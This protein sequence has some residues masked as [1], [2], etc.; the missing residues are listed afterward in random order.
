MAIEKH[1]YD[2]NGNAIYAETANINYFLTTPLEP[3]A[4]SG[5]EERTKNIPQRTVRHYVGDDDPFTVPAQTGVRYLYDPG[6]KNSNATP[7]KKFM[8][9]DG[10]EKRQFTYTGSFVDL[11]AFILGDAS[12]DV[13]LFSEGA[14]YEIKT[15]AV[16]AVQAA[17]RKK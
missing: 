3:D 15:A 5:A 14:W 13:T 1:T 4:A 16:E 17:T 12:Q 11:H 7:G 2:A 10:V 8:L 9:D 6:R